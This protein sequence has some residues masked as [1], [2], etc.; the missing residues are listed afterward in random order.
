MTGIDTATKTVGG[1]ARDQG[2]DMIAIVEERK[3]GRGR[4]TGGATK[5]VGE[6]ATAD[7]TETVRGA[8]V[9]TDVRSEVRRI[10]TVVCLTCVS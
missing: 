7:E 6:T 1:I 2:R 4:R 10:C 8:E 5:K 3:A 9:R